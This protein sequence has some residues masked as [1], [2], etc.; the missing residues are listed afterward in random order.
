M[1]SITFVTCFFDIYKNEE[2]M[3]KIDARKSIEK[4]IQY[5]EELLSTGIQVMLYISSSV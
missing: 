1:T 2:V 3:I 5:F 4:R